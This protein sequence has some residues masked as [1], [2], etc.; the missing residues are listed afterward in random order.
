[1]LVA[2]AFTA[3]AQPAQNALEFSVNRSL[4]FF[5]P[6]PAIGSANIGLSGN[7]WG[8]E[9]AYKINMADNHADYIRIFNIKTIDVVGS[10]RNFK[11]VILNNDPFTAGQLGSTYFVMGKLNIGLA[12]LGPVKLMFAPGFGLAYATQTYFT[13]QNPLTGS[14]INFASQ[15][16]LKLLTPLTKTLSV[17]AGVDVLHY[18]NG[19]YSV[20]NNGLNSFNASFGIYQK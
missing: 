6:D 4:S 19:G 9:V 2:A 3:C 11:N 13:N 7:F 10:Y 8:G 12:N 14:H 18:S 1:M 17:E 5:T 16:G 15:V 20:P